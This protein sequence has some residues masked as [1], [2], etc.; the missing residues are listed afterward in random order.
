MEKT[1]SQNIQFRIIGIEKL[2]YATFDVGEVAE[3]DIAINSDFGFGLDHENS[4][5][6]CQYKVQL[7]S[8]K[9]LFIVIEVACLFEIKETSLKKLKVRNKKQYS[10]PRNFMKNLTEITISTTRG[11]LFEKAEGNKY[12]KFILPLIELKEV[13]S[14]DLLIEY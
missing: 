8:K 7:L 2:Q 3:D 12:Q 5:V 13:F 14:E 11:V 4:I 10:F 9:K 1:D 6:A